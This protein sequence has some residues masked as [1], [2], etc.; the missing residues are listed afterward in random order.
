MTPIDQSFG[1]PANFDAAAQL[2]LSLANLPRA[3]AVEVLLLTDLAGVQAE[4]LGSFGV[5]EA[6]ADGVLLRTRT[7]SLDWFAGQLARL[8]FEFR[9]VQPDALRAALAARVARLQ[10]AIAAD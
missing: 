3:N 9:I 10:A 5:F 2:E 8:P 1:R 6:R 4:Q 7:D